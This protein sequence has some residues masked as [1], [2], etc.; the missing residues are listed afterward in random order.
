MLK[1][2]I[3]WEHNLGDSDLLSVYLSYSRLLVSC[4]LLKSVQYIKRWFLVVRAGRESCI[5]LEIIDRFSTD[6]SLR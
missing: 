5:T 6:N 2:S 1:I 3:E 4:L